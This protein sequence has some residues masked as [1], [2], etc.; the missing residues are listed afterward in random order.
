MAYPTTYADLRTRIIA[1]ARLDSTA[2]AT[3]VN[4]AINIAYAQAVVENELLVSTATTTLTANSG[5]YDLSSAS[6]IQRIKAVYLTSGGVAYAPLKAVGL[7]DIIRRRQSSTATGI[8][9]VYCLSGYKTLDLYPTPG[10][11]D[12]LTWYYVA[13]PTALS[14]DSD[15]PIISEPYGARVIEYGALVQMGEFKGDP[16]LSEWQ[17]QHDVWSA[18]LRAHLNRRKSGQPGTFEFVPDNGDPPHDPAT[19]LP[20]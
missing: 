15:V 7:D 11:A 6:A 17:Q 10:S 3:K 14:S 8:V 19:I 18:R 5:T 13:L 16:M 12:T 4:D 1:K 20:A 9:E 2:D